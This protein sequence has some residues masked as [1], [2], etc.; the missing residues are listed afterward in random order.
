M[1][2]F[3]R[4]TAAVGIIAA[5]VLGA[6]ATP[7]HAEDT[8]RIFNQETDNSS[9][10]ISFNFSAADQ[11]LT[12]DPATVKTTV[13]GRALKPDA[14]RVADQPQQD[15]TAVLVIDT[16]GSMEGN[17][18]VGARN[19]ARA[20]LDAVPDQVKVGLVTFDKTVEI[21]A[22]PTTDHAAVRRAVDRLEANGSTALYDAVTTAVRV[23]GRT[24]VRGIVLLSDGEDEASTTGLPAAVRAVR[25]A[26]D[27]RLDAVGL[28]LD[29]RG[30]QALEQL[31]NAGEGTLLRTS[32]TEVL[33][34]YFA[35]VGESLGSFVT[36]SVQ[37]PPEL[38][39]GQVS[40]TVEALAGGQVISATQLFSVGAPPARPRPTQK[41]DTRPRPL[42]LDP[43]LLSRSIVP[44]VA[45]ALVFVGVSV[46]LGFAMNAF[47]P[48]GQRGRIGRSLSIYTLGAR[49]IPVA[50]EATIFGQGAVLQGAVD[51]AGRFVAQG[52][53]EGGLRRRLDAAGLP[54]KPPEWV[55]VQVGA[56]LAV[57]LLLGALTRNLVLALLGLLIGA[58]GPVVFLMLAE[59]RRRQR[60]VDQLPD[61]LQLISGSLST[62]YSLPQ[63]VDSVVQEGTEPVAGEF[64][65]AM[66]DHRLG[67]PI[68]DSLGAIAVRM[69]SEEWHWVVMAIRIQR[70]VG[71]NL[72]ELL[73]T[74]A[75]TLRDRARMHR[76][77][78]ALSAEGRLSSYILMG[79]PIAFAIYLLIT[80]PR[81]IGVLLTD[82][83]GLLGLGLSVG[84]LIIGAFWLRRIVKV[85]I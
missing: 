56:T 19:A 9:R 55:L 50:K 49:P 83:I 80:Q 48:I 27:V 23:A 26:N 10:T 62:G 40:V 77:V 46:V 65:R 69:R 7:A 22:E 47:Q 42:A 57:P 31:T 24:G 11:T 3:A 18:I 70:D 58:A 72:A 64:N 67:R 16:S 39:D 2:L 8:G 13:D 28:E 53:F 85:E 76:Q 60:F 15:V 52:G 12:V 51:L 38:A 73:S 5:V 84:L 43:G 34:Q 6:P 1:R 29:D 44:Y 20:F 68:D 33:A 14:R 36:V 66:V 30:V 54:F 79:L 45:L 71:G 25:K 4:G 59:S 41:V 21:A 82:P 78:K 35:T 37:V 61:T 32:S 81:Y 74:V 17:K 63:A 75:D